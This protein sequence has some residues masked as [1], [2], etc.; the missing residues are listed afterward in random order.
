MRKRRG[1]LAGSILPRFHNR[2]LF[3]VDP[4]LESGGGSQGG[5][6]T[7]VIE[8]DIPPSNGG[9]DRSFDDLANGTV[10]E[11]SPIT[12]AP[13]V[14][15]DPNQR[16]GLTQTQPVANDW[17]SIRDAATALGYQFA[18]NVAD[19]RAALVHLI[20]QANG[21]RQADYYAQLGRQLAPQAPAIQQYLQAQ[22]AP[23]APTAPPAWEA[24]EFDER[25]AGLVDRD[26]TT[27]IY[28]A[29]QGV[30]HEIA[31]K[32]N[33][34]VEWK[35]NYDRNPA[36]VING[37]VQAQARAIA[38]ETFDTQFAQQQRQSTVNQ[39]AQDNSAWF[40]QQDA[41]GQR[42]INPVT[43]QYIPSPVGA[44]YLHHLGQVQ[45]M[46]VTDPRQQD[47]LAKNLVRGEVAMQAQATA[48]AA[49]QQ[50]ANPQT[51]QA[52]TR[53]NVNPLQAQPPTQRRQNPSATEP[54]ATGM[55]LQEMLRADLAAEGVTDADFANINQ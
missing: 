6:T 46:G 26:P 13:P 29:K 40:Y 34:Y 31:T 53:P 39:I 21:N 28:V 11:P 12:S 33:K 2:F 41:N 18:P 15:A 36:A 17:Q 32:V 52:I 10:A 5:T 43:N 22:H 8:P 23:A 44:R 1:F 37:M 27:G 3:D 20:Q 38:K 24:P 42:A 55:S 45:Q 50:A 14:P 54:S 48:Y 35:A 51:N 7:T 25:W 9:P 16:A 19:D 47:A 30:P 49:T 4:P